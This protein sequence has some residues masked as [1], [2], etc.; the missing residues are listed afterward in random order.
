MSLITRPN[1]KGWRRV[2]ADYISRWGEG[3]IG[4]F[5]QQNNNAS[6]STAVTLDTPPESAL[7]RIIACLKTTTLDAVSC[8]LPKLTLTWTDADSGASLSQDVTAT[9]AATNLQVQS[10]GQILIKAQAGVA[11][12][13]VTSGYVS[14]TANQ[15]IY[16]INVAVE[17]L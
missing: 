7:R 17:A 15:M 3:L 11:I 16:G 8:T 5:D 14:H 12:T 10:N 9:V 6:I 1:F 2:A 4:V 13:F